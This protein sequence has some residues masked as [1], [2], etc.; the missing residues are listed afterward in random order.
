[1]VDITQ[2]DIPSNVLELLKMILAARTRGEQAV[3]ILETR[4]GTLATKFRST[5]SEAGTPASP[6]LTRPTKRK[7]PSRARRSQ[8]RLEKFKLKKIEEERKAVHLHAGTQLEG[9]TSHAAGDSS[10]R[11]VLKLSSNKEMPM[12]SSLSNSILQVDGLDCPVDKE[13]AKFTFVSNYGKED[14][15]YTLEEIFPEKNC[16]LSSYVRYKPKSADHLCNV[17]VNECPD[18]F[19]WPPMNSLQNEVIRELKKA[20]S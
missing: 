12:D 8:L 9:V 1:M 7:T 6:T 13:N 15:E 19:V 10:Q 4:N 3:L 2:S 20:K 16:T 14:I 11:L 18:G 17:S 5:E